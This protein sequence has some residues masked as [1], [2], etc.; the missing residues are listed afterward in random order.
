M[1]AEDIFDGLG[2]HFG[3]QNAS[4]LHGEH[5][6]WV[7]KFGGDH[8]PTSAGFGLAVCALSFLRI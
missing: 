2:G 7:A 6:F 4:Y 5:F 8:V 3:A 1:G